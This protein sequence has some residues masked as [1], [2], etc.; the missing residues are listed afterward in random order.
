MTGFILSGVTS[1]STT[2]ISC[3]KMAP[4]FVKDRQRLELQLNVGFLVT[5]ERGHIEIGIPGE[6]DFIRLFAP[7]LA[8]EV[9][10]DDMRIGK[11]RHTNVF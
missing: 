5:E 9:A 8:G 3:R 6:S 1:A 4:F 7:N 11:P 2:S 10:E